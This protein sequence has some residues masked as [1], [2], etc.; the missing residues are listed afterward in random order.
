MKKKVEK[1][2]KIFLSFIEFLKNE[3]GFVNITS[4]C[5]IHHDVRDFTL[6][7][8]IS[9]I[10]LENDLAIHKA[11]SNHTLMLSEKGIKL[12]ESDYQYLFENYK[13]ITPFHKKPLFIA[14]VYPLT[15][16]LLSFLVLP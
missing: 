6:S 12:S 11:D 8:K 13:L 15:I 1:H 9:Y 4:Y 14:T 3:N 10:L 7:D 16:L 2:L 5:E